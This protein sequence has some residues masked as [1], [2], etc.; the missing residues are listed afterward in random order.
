MLIF[1]LIVIVMVGWDIGRGNNLC[2]GE[3]RG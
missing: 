3:E 2:A 1:I